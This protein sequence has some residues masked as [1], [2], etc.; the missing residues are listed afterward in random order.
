MTARTRK[1]FTFSNIIACMA[2][3]VALGGSVYAAAKING[4]QIKAGSL[5][6]NR[7]KPRTITAR[8][9]K[10]KTLTGRQV[11]PLS[12]TGKQINQ[13]TLTKI[14]AAALA[15]VQYEATTVQ[16]SESGRPGTT[17]TASC[18]SGTYVVGG[19]ATVSNEEEATVN[20]SGPSPLRTGWT[21]TAF[22]WW[23]K[24][25]MTVTAIC[26]AVQKPGGGSTT[27]A[28]Q[29]HPTPQYQPLR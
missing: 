23:P 1:V 20:D 9:I 6:G 4:K 8:R 25:T 15:S 16:L 22:A 26:V 29:Y 24:P 10:L 27:T 5:P 3:F 12:L 13:K 14:N 28:P 18:P 2:L 21:A 17:A 7:L 19:G 11:K